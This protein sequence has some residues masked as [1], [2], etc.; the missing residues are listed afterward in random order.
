MATVH[1][2]T[3]ERT[4][5]IENKTVVTGYVDSNGILKLETRDGDVITAGYVQGASTLVNVNHGSNPTEARPNSV[6]VHWIGVATPAN[7]LP[8]DFWTAVNLPE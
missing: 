6:L 3:A 2:L 5:Q 1:A 4:L 8:H 7:A